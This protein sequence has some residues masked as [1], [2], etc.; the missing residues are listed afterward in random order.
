M[1]VSRAKDR[2]QAMDANGEQ[3]RGRATRSH[4]YHGD[5]EVYSDF[6]DRPM[7]VKIK[8]CKKCSK[9][10]PKGAEGR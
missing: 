8:L 1:K 6:S 4:C 7:W 9:D 2:C 3:C 10:M 5:H